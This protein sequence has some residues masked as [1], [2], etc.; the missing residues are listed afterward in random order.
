M[1]DIKYK[2]GEKGAR[3]WGEWEVIDTGER[4]IVKKITVNPGEILSLQKHNYRSEHWIIADGEAEVTIDGTA[5]KAGRDKAFYIPVKSWHRIRNSG[6]DK[7]IFIEVQ[8]GDILDEG[9]I[10][11]KEDVYGRV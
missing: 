2:K 1:A 5:F 7:M 9:D 3:P 6:S 4:F 10:E 8:T 11:R